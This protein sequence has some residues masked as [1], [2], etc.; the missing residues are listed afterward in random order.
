MVPL[1]QEIKRDNL[2]ITG[3]SAT[4]AEV[5]AAADTQTGAVA[6]NQSSSITTDCVFKLCKDNLGVPI[7]ANE[8]S[9]AFRLK[10]R[11][12]DIHHPIVVRFI[13]R[14]TRDQVYA[15]KSKLKQL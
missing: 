3:V 13:K 6:K 12:G 8:I 1:E 7:K 4:F 11:C 10:A 14:S 2:I 9:I 5:T 15:S